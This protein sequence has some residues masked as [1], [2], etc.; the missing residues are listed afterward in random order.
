MTVVG[1]QHGRISAGICVWLINKPMK[2]FY[3]ELTPE[4]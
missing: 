2:R 3:G 1:S 4:L